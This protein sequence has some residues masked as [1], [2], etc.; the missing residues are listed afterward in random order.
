MGKKFRHRIARALGYDMLERSENHKLDI[1]HYVVDLL[2][3]FSVNCVIDVGANVGQYATDLRKAGYQGRIASFEPNPH[4]ADALRVAAAA[5]RN[6]FCY[7]AALG[8]QA[9]SEL[10]YLT[11]ESKLTSF[12]P[13]SEF[14]RE[15]FGERIVDAERGEVETMRLDL[16][17]D[18]VVKGL[19]SPRVYLKFD[20]QGYDL[21]AFEGARNCLSSVVGLQSELSV[22]ALYEDMPDYIEALQ[23]YRAS[24][25]EVS[26]FFPVFHVEPS[27]VLGEFDCVMVRVD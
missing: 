25:F 23:I 27:M 8:S 18:E 16:L 21:Q 9:G 5:D 13:P 11:S 6:W 22:S 3:R 10:M 14:G 2:A 1:E 15:R 7:E 26:G 19:D 24:G 17:F 4:C 20:T 12:L